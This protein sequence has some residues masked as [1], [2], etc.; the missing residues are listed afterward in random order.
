MQQA[1]V[2][3][4]ADMGAQPATL[5]SGLVAATH[6][7]RPRRRRRRSSRRRRPARPSRSGTPVTVTGTASD[8]GGGHVGGV[9]VSTDGGATWHPAAGTTSW[10]Y[11]WTVDRLRRRCTSGP[12]RSTTAATSRRP[13][14]GVAVT[15][16]LPVPLCARRTRLP[17]TPASGDSAAVEVGVKFQSS[18]SGWITGDSLLQGLDATPAPTSGASG[19]AAGTLLASCDRSPARRAIGLAGG[20]AS[21]YPV[22]VNAGHDVRRVVLRAQRALRRSTSNYFGRPRH[23]AALHRARRTAPP[24]ATASTRTAR[25]RASRPHATARATTG[26]TSSS[27][28]VQP[29]DTRPPTRRVD[30]PGR[31]RRSSTDAQADVVATFSEAIDAGDGERVDGRAPRRLGRARAL[32]CALRRAD[33]KRT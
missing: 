26:S 11:T 33:A 25:R 27:A 2:N 28:T 10:T 18:Q 22:A 21:T 3:L 14:A 29:A 9:E 30:D 17:G 23:D 31:R 20:A 32:D 24:A 13:A 4:F 15:V 5:Q 7:D 16:G 8:T 12:A 6:V 1:T 19:R